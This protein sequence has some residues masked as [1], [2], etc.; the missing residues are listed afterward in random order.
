MTK[1][2]DSLR[3]KMPFQQI[4]IL[5]AKELIEA[6]TAAIVD[7]RDAD[8]YKTAHIENAFSLSNSN[9]ESF[10][11]TADKN[12][13]LICYCYHGVSSQGAAE[14][15]AEKGFKEVYSIEGGFELWRQNYPS[16]DK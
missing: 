1:F 8:S 14:F 7:I 5:R 12:K 2:R 3:V 11:N 16:T 13:P 10:L 15:L 4:D 9:I 6:G